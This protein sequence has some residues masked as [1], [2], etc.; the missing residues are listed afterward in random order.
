MLGWLRENPLVLMDFETRVHNLMTRISAGI[1]FALE[2]GVLANVEGDLEGRVMARRPR[3]LK[4]TYDWESCMKSSEFL[5]K[6]FGVS[7]SDQATV[8]A[9]WGFRP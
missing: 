1:S 6:W 7:G 9:G 4:P 3:M 2:H 8:L 5:G